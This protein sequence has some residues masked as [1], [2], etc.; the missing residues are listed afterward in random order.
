[1]AQNSA[2]AELMAHASEASYVST[3]DDYETRWVTGQI[4]GSSAFGN[5]YTLETEFSD[6]T[7]DPRQTGV[8]VGFLLKEMPELYT[9]EGEQPKR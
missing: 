6:Q 9:Q 2:L 4:A 1:M 7:T 8:V 3:T 5:G